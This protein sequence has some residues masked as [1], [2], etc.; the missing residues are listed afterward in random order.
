MYDLKQ[1]LQA[2]D[3]KDID[4]ILEFAKEKSKENSYG[5]REIDLPSWPHKK[6]VVSECPSVIR[7]D[8][9]RHKTHYV[10]VSKVR[11]ILDQF[12][13]NI[14][15]MAC[16]KR[17]TLVGFKETFDSDEWE[18]DGI[19]HELRR[20]GYERRENDNVFYNVKFP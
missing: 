18:Y 3:C 11:S 2:R 9:Y 16:N 4:A 19:I 13:A 8:Y 17:L 14:D 6:Y 5:Y 15:F 12:A 7:D 20:L 10:F 1:T